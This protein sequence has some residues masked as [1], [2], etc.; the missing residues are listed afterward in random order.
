MKYFDHPDRWSVWDRGLADTGL[1]ERAFTTCS[2]H[3]GKIIYVRMV[4]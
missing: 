4:L 3:M 2:H 1:V